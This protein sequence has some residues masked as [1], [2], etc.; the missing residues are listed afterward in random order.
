MERIFLTTWDATY[1]NHRLE[2]PEGR[3]VEPKEAR[4]HGNDP[5]ADDSAGR[6]DPDGGAAVA[7]AGTGRGY[8]VL[9]S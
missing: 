7:G 2:G 9:L 1:L 3:P 6:R 5:G 4:V 8:F